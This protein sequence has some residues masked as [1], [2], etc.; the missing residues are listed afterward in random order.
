MPGFGYKKG[1]KI[2][3]KKTHKYVKIDLLIFLIA[4]MTFLK[5]SAGPLFTRIL[6]MQKV[7]IRT[8]L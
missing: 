8:Y 7:A 6:L 1:G 4:D 5:I 3:S 2:E